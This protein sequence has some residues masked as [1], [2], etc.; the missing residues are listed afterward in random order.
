MLRARY[1][2]AACGTCG[3]A[4]STLGVAPAAARWTYGPST[5]VHSGHAHRAHP[6]LAVGDRVL[7]VS[8]GTAAYVSGVVHHLY[9]KQIVALQRFTAGGGWETLARDRTD[10]HGRYRLVY[11]PRRPGSS[12]VR[13]RVIGD[14]RT[15]A[16]SRSLGHLNAFRSAMASWYGPGLFGNQTACGFVLTANIMGVAHRTLPCGTHLI[17]RNGARTARVEVIDRGPF[18]AGREFDLTAAVK[19]ALGFGSTGLVGATA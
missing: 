8:D 13:L 14:A 2:M 15:R 16:T 18:V 6:S 4:F 9:H 3:L 12:R 10:H 17:L 7:D 19:R 11:R 5:H 1:A